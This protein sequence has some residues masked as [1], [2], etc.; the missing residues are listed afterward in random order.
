[1]TM[2]V[3]DHSP[4]T[5]IVSGLCILAAIAFQAPSTNHEL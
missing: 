1:V 4:Y 2:R 3:D 5:P